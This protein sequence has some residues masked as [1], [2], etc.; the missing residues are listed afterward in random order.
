[1][2]NYLDIFLAPCQAT[3]ILA[4]MC[5]WPRA[6]HAAELVY[7]LTRPYSLNLLSRERRA[8]EATE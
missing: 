2:Y 4:T 3:L 6:Y 5:I 1:M 8:F 7:Q